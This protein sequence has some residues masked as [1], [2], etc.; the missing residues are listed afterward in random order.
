M[1]SGVS[2]HVSEL[3][4]FKNLKHHKL[5]QISA[6]M[7]IMKQ[8]SNWGQKADFSFSTENLHVCVSFALLNNLSTSSHNLIMNNVPI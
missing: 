3:L 8:K 5:A 1:F 7:K 6:G 2:R 4:P